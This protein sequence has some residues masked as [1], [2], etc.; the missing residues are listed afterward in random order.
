MCNG[1][2][3]AVLLYKQNAMR[4]HILKSIEDGVMIMYWAVVSLMSAL[5]NIISYFCTSVHKHTLSSS[6]YDRTSS[7]KC[8]NSHIYT[9]GRLIV[10]GL[11]NKN[12]LH[13]LCIDILNN[14]QPVTQPDSRLHNG[15][16]GYA[17]GQP[18]AQ[19]D[20]R[21]HNGTA[22][23]ETGQPVTQPASGYVTGHPY[24]TYTSVCNFVVLDLTAK[25]PRHA[26]FGC[27]NCL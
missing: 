12:N 18:V 10:S 21:L 24:G 14:G 3:P 6:Q 11:T 22:S 4:K 19:R 7:H 5:Y 25:I 17:T 8:A 23:Y 27:C 13:E 2:D 20:S 16:A 1:Q 15:T 9:D 26:L